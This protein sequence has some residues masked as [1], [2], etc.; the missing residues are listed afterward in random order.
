MLRNADFTVHFDNSLWSLLGIT[1][2]LSLEI[3]CTQSPIFNPSLPNEIFLKSLDLS[4]TYITVVRLVIEM[5]VFNKNSVD[6]DQTPRCAVSDLGLHSL[7]IFLLWNSSLKRVKKKKT[8]W[9]QNKLNNITIQ[10]LS[11]I[12]HLFGSNVGENNSNHLMTNPT[13]WMCT[14][15]QISLGIRPVWSETSLFAQWVAKDPSYRHADSK[16]SDQIGRM[17]HHEN[18]PI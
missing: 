8:L 11:N 18:I 16:D 1:N 7:P 9:D 6:P 13:K 4:I 3:S 12:S 17:P 2:Q 10:Y 14:Q 15:R 5:A